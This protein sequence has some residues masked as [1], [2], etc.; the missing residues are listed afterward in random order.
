[1]HI[2][3]LFTFTIKLKHKDPAVD[4]LIKLHHDHL[5][6][7]PSPLIYAFFKWM[8]VNLISEF[9]ASLITSAHTIT[10]FNTKG[11]CSINAHGGIHFIKCI[12]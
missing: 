7:P 10:S 9:A 11:Q 8:H 6:H 2:N 12:S 1:M 3:G 4:C 5:L